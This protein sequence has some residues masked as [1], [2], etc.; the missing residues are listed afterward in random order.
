MQVRLPKSYIV[1]AVETSKN[2]NSKL[3]RALP[4]QVRYFMCSD[5]LMFTELIEELCHFLSNDKV[6]RKSVLTI[7]VGEGCFPWSRLPIIFNFDFLM[8]APS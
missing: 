2:T 5:D 4:T 1:T 6:C 7:L 8:I 3:P